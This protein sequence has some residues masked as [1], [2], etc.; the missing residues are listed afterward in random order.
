MGR[1]DGFIAVPRVL[2]KDPKFRPAYLKIW[3][4]IHEAGEWDVP[5]DDLARTVMVHRTRACNIL[6]EMEIAG[7]VTRER[8]KGKPSIF[9]AILP[10]EQQKTE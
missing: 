7:Y 1:E 8:R 3:A 10:H 6:R 5:V 2:I 9:R 4:L